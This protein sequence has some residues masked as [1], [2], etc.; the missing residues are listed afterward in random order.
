MLM[1]GNETHPHESYLNP[2]VFLYLKTM[3][4]STYYYSSLMFLSKRL[5]RV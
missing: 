3:F 5:T 4:S 1:Y 2:Y